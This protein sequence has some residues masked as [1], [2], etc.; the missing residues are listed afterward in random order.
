MSRIC[1]LFLLSVLLGVQPLEAST[2]Q[3]DYEWGAEYFQ[4]SQYDQALPF[5]QAAAQKDPQNWLA[6][7]NNRVRPLEYT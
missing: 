1:F 2:A 7:Q 3:E 5:F 6:Y 4:K